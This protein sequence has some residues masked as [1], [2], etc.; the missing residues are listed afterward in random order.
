MA[1]IATVVVAASRVNV[2]IALLLIRTKLAVDRDISSQS[3]T[4]PLTTMTRPHSSV[5]LWKSWRTLGLAAR[6]GS[7]G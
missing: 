4:L 2:M 1:D 7:I 3:V 6:A 5:S